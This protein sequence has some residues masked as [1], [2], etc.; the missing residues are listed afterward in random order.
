MNQALLRLALCLAIFFGVVTPMGFSQEASTQG[1]PAPALAAP[2]PAP[3][4]QA[5]EFPALPTAAEGMGAEAWYFE[6]KKMEQAAKGAKTDS[7]SLEF[8]YRLAF[9]F[10]EKTA[11]RE[12]GKSLIAF[13]QAANRNADATASAR[14]WLAEFGPDWDIYKSLIAI[15]FVSEN[16][17]GILEQVA[18]V[19]KNLSSTAKTRTN[20]LS[21]YEYFAKSALG[22]IAWTP[23]S[24]V[25]LRSYSIDAWGAKILRLAATTPASP[26]YS[27][28]KELALMRADFFEKNYNQ[29]SLHA[30]NAQ[31]SLHGPKTARQLIS[32]AGKSFMN[33]S[34]LANGIPFFA[35][36][37]PGMQ[38][39]DPDGIHA[40]LVAAKWEERLWVA[41]FYLARLWQAA[42][43]ERDAGILFLA[44]S[45]EAPSAGDADGALWYWL[46]ITMRRI[47]SNDFEDLETLPANGNALGAASGAA[48]SLE[49][50]AYVEASTH[51]KN[52]ASFDDLVDAFARKLLREK[53]WDDAVSLSLLIDDRVSKS[54]GIRL[55]YLSARL[56]EEKY[57]K[58][59]LAQEESPIAKASV[60]YKTILA[61][62]EAEEYYRTMS[63]WRLGQSPAYLASMPDLSTTSVVAK[64]PTDPLSTNGSANGT[65]ASLEL[66]G[67]Y[68]AYDLGNLAASVAVNFIGNPDKSLVASLAFQLSRQGEYNA[69]LRLARDA[70]NRGM[71]SQYP[72]LYGL[73]YP[74]AWQG[75]VEEAARIPDVPP[76]LAYGIIRSESVFDPRAVSY[77]GAVGLSQLM[78]ATARDTASGLKMTNYSLTEPADNLKIGMTYYSYMMARFGRRPMRAMFAYNAGPSRMLAW[79]KESGELP[80]DILLETLHLSQPRQYAKNI[81]QATLAYGKIH[82]SIEPA[83]LLDYLVLGKPLPAKVPALPT[84]MAEPVIVAPVNVPPAAT[85]PIIVAPPPPEPIAVP[86]GII[87]E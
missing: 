51:W 8:F 1:A 14:E 27:T 74:K 46:D 83:V 15:A 54:M 38:E 16:P 68:L 60:A 26:L 17:S 52:A 85:E 44:L 81:I 13:Y 31:E 11:A 78:P 19:R 86:H 43:Y 65:K 10:G 25:Y 70:I 67:D 75:L 59:S 34:D 84:V 12:A 72:E 87:E 56:I 73:I 2:E 63:A 79:D 45:D 22:D 33:S 41:A 32:E 30:V 6:A 77:A 3:P 42:G 49:F 66:I 50:A 82:Y 37:F 28:S 61:D 24:L 69:A 58:A 7:A 57:S 80:D 53:S 21:Y 29:A 23:E 9:A 35:S 62:I 36:Y 76:A 47:T 64:T 39:R 5:S 55:K 48:R 4:V 18:A 40:A 71:G 20:E